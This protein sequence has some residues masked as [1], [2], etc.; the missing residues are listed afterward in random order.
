MR[1][2]NDFLTVQTKQKREFL[3]ITETVRH[4]LE[5]SGV[6]EGMILVA[7]LHTNAALFL[8]QEEPGLLQDVDAWLSKTAPAHGDYHHGTRFESNA[9]IHLQALLLNPQV[10][11]PV[12]SG[13]MEL[14]PWQQVIYA[15]LDGQRPKKL[16]IKVMGE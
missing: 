6:T 10:I 8:N 3:N 11:V 16:L 2:H 13:R 14:G 7:A 9:A 1:V 12:N 15:E 4:A 5:K